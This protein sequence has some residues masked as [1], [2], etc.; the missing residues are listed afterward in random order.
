MSGIYWVVHEESGLKNQQDIE[1]S[2]N[3]QMI[4]NLDW[5]LRVFDF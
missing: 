1:T 4:E 3:F 5:T 2:F